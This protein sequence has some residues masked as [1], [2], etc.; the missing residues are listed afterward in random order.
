MTTAKFTI[1][2]FGDEIAADLLL[3]PAALKLDLRLGRLELL[4]RLE[5]SVDG[6]LVRASA[7]ELVL[8]RRE[9]VEGPTVV[10]RL[11][12][13]CLLFAKL[14]AL[15]LAGIEPSHGAR[16]L[17]LEVRAPVRQHGFVEGLHVFVPAEHSIGQHD[18]EF[19]VGTTEVVRLGF[20][21]V[22]ESVLKVLQVATVGRVF[23]SSAPDSSIDLIGSCLQA[24]VL[25][26]DAERGH[27]LLQTTH[28]D[29]GGGDLTAQLRDGS[30]DEAE[31]GVLRGRLELPAQ[32]FTA[33]E[34]LVASGESPVQTE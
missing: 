9:R 12:Q 6:L 14:P 20:A 10:Q 26:D 15:R 29:G 21:F 19:L 30:D 24:L 28:A 27:L 31:R 4:G 17:L 8:E 18:A 23:S 5:S 3:Q 16:D 7:R 13:T 32:G 1:S 34:L 11:E 33:S 22:A 2:A 25:G